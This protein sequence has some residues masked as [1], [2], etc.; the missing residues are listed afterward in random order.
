MTPPASRQSSYSRRSQYG[1]FAVYVVA[2]TAIIGGLLSAILSVVDPAGFAALRGTVAEVIAPIGR[3]AGSGTGSVSNIDD[4]IA[5]YWRAGSQN[6]RLNRELV[7]ARRELLTARGL[8]AENR[9]LRAL[10]NLR[11]QSDTAVATVR[12]IS[13]TA[14]SAR[15]YAIIDGGRADGIATRM[16][17]RNADGLIGRTLDVGMNVTRILLITDAQSVVPVRRA[18]DGLPAQVTGRGDAMLEV[19][20]L[21]TA[22]NPLRVGDVLLSSGSGGLYQPGTPV[23]L[24]IRVTEDGALARSIAD[25]ATTDAV[26]VDRAADAGLDL[27]PERSAPGAPAAARGAQP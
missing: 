2:I 17:V 15:R 6:A 16:P 23:A 9:Q 8:R 1:A 7:A 11:G 26:I 3:A 14:A 20:T 22:N 21:N 25:P 27:P 19:R 4:E 13:S 5:A 18:S 10:L 24:I 12:L